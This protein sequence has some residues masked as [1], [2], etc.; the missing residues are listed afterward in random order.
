MDRCGFAP[1]MI[2]FW[3]GITENITDVLQPIKWQCSYQSTSLLSSTYS[4]TIHR[5]LYVCKDC[6]VV[7]F[8]ACVVSTY[9]RLIPPAIWL[10]FNQLSASGRRN[11]CLMTPIGETGLE[12]VPFA[13]C[14]AMCFRT[15][16][17][18]LEVIYLEG[19]PLKGFFVFWKIFRINLMCFRMFYRL[20]CI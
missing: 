14:N 8:S 16:S 17:P 9:I 18:Y 3:K 2:D 15:L 1:H 19:V 6:A 11:S 7:L 5:P 12:P 13:P 4:D 10:A 20:V